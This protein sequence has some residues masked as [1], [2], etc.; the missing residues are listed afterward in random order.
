ME[1]AG[2]LFLHLA[3]Q[4]FNTVVGSAPSVYNVST[5]GRDFVFQILGRLGVGEDVNGG[6]RD[7]QPGFQ[8]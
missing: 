7:G 4:A 1:E 6:S 3:A 8:Q 2:Q 5:D